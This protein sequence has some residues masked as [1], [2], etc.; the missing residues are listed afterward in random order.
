MLVFLVEGGVTGNPKLA[1]PSAWTDWLLDVHLRLPRYNNTMAIYFCNL[2]CK[3]SS[4]KM[5]S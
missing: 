4:Q 1:H 2:C 3:F 5:Y